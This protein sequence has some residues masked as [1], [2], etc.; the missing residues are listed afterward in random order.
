MG[1]ASKGASVF[2]VDKVRAFDTLTHE[3]VA[4]RYAE[5]DNRTHDEVERTTGNVTISRRLNPIGKNGKTDY[6]KMMFMHVEVVNSPYGHAMKYS[7]CPHN[8][9][10]YG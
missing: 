6:N 9:A 5:Y 4:S 2:D 7:N 8:F 3:L 1:H 10:G